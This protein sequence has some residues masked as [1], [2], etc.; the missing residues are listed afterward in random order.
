M[1]D[2]TDKIERSLK[3][4]D[5]L[6]LAIKAT[7][8]HKFREQLKGTDKEIDEYING[9]VP[10]VQGLLISL[11]IAEDMLHETCTE[12][13]SW[14]NLWRGCERKRWDEYI[15]RKKDFAVEFKAK[16]EEDAKKVKLQRVEK[17]AEEKA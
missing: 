9:T 1:S 16:V 4:L 11:I 8:G 13:P 3:G 7:G 12:K 17:P 10:K 14:K 15:Q 5:G 6:L 2:L